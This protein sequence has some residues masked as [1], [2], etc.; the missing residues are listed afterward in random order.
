M[1]EVMGQGDIG[2]SD[3][4][5]R[6]V[7]WI[8]QMTPQPSF[9]K[10]HKIAIDSPELSGCDESEIKKA[11][12]DMLRDRKEG[13]EMKAG[14]KKNERNKDQKSESISDRKDYLYRRYRIVSGFKGELFVANAYTATGSRLI[15]SLNGDNP[16]DVT[17]KVKEYLDSHLEELKKRSDDH[18]VPCAEEYGEAFES[19]KDP[20]S[21]QVARVLK[22]YAEKRQGV[23]TIKDMMRDI[24]CVT[25][26]E[27]DTL[28]VKLGKSLSVYTGFKPETKELPAS[29][30]P[31]N[32]LAVPQGQ[33][34]EGLWEWTLRP[35]VIEALKTARI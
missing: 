8:I 34:A 5:K 31:F 4:V 22:Y 13:M 16:E 24:D 32:I 6:T 7:S 23:L 1:G 14:N 26:K 25:L 20:A 10:V 28:C 33:R 15:A 12:H 29:L 35:Q 9:E 17:Q 11:I 27:A 19:L 30:A 21:K 18:G 3:V 2:M